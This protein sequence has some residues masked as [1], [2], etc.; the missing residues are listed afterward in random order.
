[1]AEVEKKE[2]N[3][4]RKWKATWIQC[5]GRDEDMN[6]LVKTLWMFVVGSWQVATSTSNVGV[7]RQG[8]GAKR[9]TTVVN[10]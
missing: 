6:D 7:D 8:Q 10:S 9:M 5:Q 3:N 1:M 4:L 2:S